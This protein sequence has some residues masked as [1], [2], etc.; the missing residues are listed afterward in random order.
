[1][2]RER[3][4]WLGWA[5]GAAILALILLH[6]SRS[7]QWREFNWSRLWFLLIHA[8]AG[9][10][11]LAIGIG[12]ASYF[13]RAYRWKYFVDPLKK[14][15]FLALF[16]AQVIG[17]SSIYLIGRAGEI[18]RPA[19]VAKAEK[20]SFSSQIAVWVIER[21]YDCVALA[22]LLGL[23][24]YFHPLHASTRHPTLLH[25]LRR[26]AALILALSAAAI[27]GLAVFRFR[28]KQAVEAA[29][30][31]FQ[32]APQRIRARIRNLLDSFASGLGVI[33]NADD[34][35][36]TVAWTVLLWSINVTVLWLV[37]R[38]AGGPLAAFSWWGAA[39]TAFLCALGLAIQLPGIGGGYQV[40]I[41]LS[42]KDLFHIPAEEAAGAAIL[43]WVA[44]MGPCLI[45]GLILVAAGGLSFR[46]LQVMAEAEQ[47]KISAPE[48]SASL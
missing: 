27:A 17:F 28:S 31:V 1:M 13:A 5:V 12:Y 24:L 33:Q 41:L 2:K 42:L 23:A 34:F 47:R 9:L 45:L 40:A 36:A 48:S 37:I 7:P 35:Y 6:V 25:D 43:S 3:R 10:L 30:R 44:V 32:F 15:S 29:G 4:R 16:N 22:I 8:N 21:I 11:I 46:K 18:V 26:G 38:G 19:Y 39:L 20:L 14:C